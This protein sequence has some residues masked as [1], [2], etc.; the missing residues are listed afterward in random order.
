MYS[1]CII[2]VVQVDTLSH[3]FIYSLPPPS[4]HLL[5]NFCIDPAC[6]SRL[7]V[8]VPASPPTGTTS[9]GSCPARVGTTLPLPR[10]RRRLMAVRQGS[11]LLVLRESLH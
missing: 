2:D 8:A 9:T 5:I 3:K 6:H 1:T 11:H 10:P 7:Q 4:L